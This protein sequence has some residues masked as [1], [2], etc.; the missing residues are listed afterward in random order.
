MYIE[1]KY[2]IL[3]INIVPSRQKLGIIFE[4]KIEVI[5]KYQY[6][7]VFPYIILLK[8]IFSD[9]QMDFDNQNWLW[10]S[11]FGIFWRT[12]SL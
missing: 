8:K 10:K 12:V 2:S 6:Q 5:K 11:D 3:W 1:G 9:I 4:N 7:N